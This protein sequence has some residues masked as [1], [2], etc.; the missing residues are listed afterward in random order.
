M[1]KA[2]RLRRGTGQLRVD[3]AAFHSNWDRGVALRANLWD[4]SKTLC[5]GLILCHPFIHFRHSRPSTLDRASLLRLN[6]RGELEMFCHRPNEF[7]SNRSYLPA[8]PGCLG[9]LGLQS[10]V[11][12]RRTY[13][14]PLASLEIADFHPKQ[15]A[16]SPSPSC[17]AQNE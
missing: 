5:R 11:Q 16:I 2:R 9:C 12:P 4:G 6:L 15:R 14:P 1:K 7:L 17:P 10:P 8:C 13:R 3:G